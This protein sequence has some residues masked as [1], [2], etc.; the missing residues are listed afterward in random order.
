MVYKIS[1]NGNT[2][3]CILIQ[4]SNADG[5]QCDLLYIILPYI[6]ATAH[7]VA[8]KRWCLNTVL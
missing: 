5:V 4:I 3:R 6:I 2:S 8:E 1:L 7:T